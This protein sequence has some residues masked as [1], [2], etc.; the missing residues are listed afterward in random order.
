MSKYFDQDKA[1]EGI[2]DDMA[3]L[4]EENTE[5]NRQELVDLFKEKYGHVYEIDMPYVN[6]EGED[7]SMPFV[8]KKPRPLA[9][10]R[11]LTT[12]QKRPTRAMADLLLGGVVAEQKQALEKFIKDNP[13]ASSSASTE[14]LRLLGFSDKTVLRML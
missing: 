11:F 14:Y 8:F 3:F 6:E 4:E 12:M 13:A 7:A 9:Y 5:M 2:T 10:D 1:S